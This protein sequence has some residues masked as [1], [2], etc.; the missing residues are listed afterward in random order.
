MLD[1]AADEGYLTTS[2]NIIHL[3]Q[4]VIQGRWYSDSSLLVLPS[5]DANH[6][7]ALARMN[8]S[9]LALPHLIHLAADHRQKVT[10]AL[11]QLMSSTQADDVIQVLTRLP[12]I[13]V[14]LKLHGVNARQLAV[15]TEYTLKV[16]V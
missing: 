7:D 5:L 2:L 15:D 1:A 10:S 16:C 14:T 8:P 12:R 9:I 13:I 3:M 6:V 4:M 11:R